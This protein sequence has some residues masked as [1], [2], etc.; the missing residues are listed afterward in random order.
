VPDDNVGVAIRLL[1]GFEVSVAG[2]PVSADAWRLRKAKT[3]V[4]LLALAHGHRIHRDVLADVL[5]PGRTP[6]SASNNLHQA[7]YAAR[8]ALGGAPVAMFRLHEDVVLLADGTLPWLDT[9]A[10][11]E[12]CRR[13][14]ET[15]DPGDFALAAQLYRGDLLPEDRFEDWADAPR[16]AYRD[17]RLGLLADYAGA[18]LER[19]E[20]AQVVDIAG[21]VTAADPFHEG[22]YRILMAAL[23][24]S[25]RRYEALAAFDR[26]REAL[27]TEHAADPEPATRRLYRE[28]LTGTEPTSGMTTDTALSVAQ[29]QLTRATPQTRAPGVLNGHLDQTSFVGRRREMAEIVAAL[30]RTR[31]LTLTGPG[32]AGKTRLAYQVANG[33]LAGF[34][35]GIHLVE[36]ASLTR[37]ELVPQTVASVLDVPLP[38]TGTAEIVLARQVGERHLLLVMDNCEHLLEACARLVGELLRRCPGVVVL[39]TS[40]EPLRVGGEVTWRTP[41]LALP[42][43]RAQL[44]LDDLAQLE[45]VRLFVERARDASP[46]FVLD[47]ETAPAVAE[48]CRRL[49]GMPLALELAAAR[50]SALAP[51]QIADRLGDAMRVLDRGSRS[52]VTRQQTLQATLSWSH[53]LLDAGERVLFRRLAVFAGSMPLE[54]VEQVCGGDD[55]DPLEVVDL[56]SR[57]VDKS[58]VQAEPGGGTVR[59]RLL[60]TIRQFADRKLR[61]SGEAH[62]L[63]RRHRD[64]YVTFAAE[65]DPEQATGVVNDTP[66][67][68][69]DEHDNLRAALSSGL[70]EDPAVALRLAV[71]LWRFWLA[72]GHFSEGSRWLRA[73][74]DAAPQGSSLRV[75]A[76]FAAAAMAVRRGD[77][78]IQV[79]RLGT[80][81][82]SIMRETGDTRAL[83]RTLHLAALL[84][85]V[86]DG[87]SSHSVGL[88]EEART[89]ANSAG[90][91]DVAVSATHLLGVM[92]LSRGAGPEGE[93]YL[94][95]TLEA[96]EH[97]PA[98]L[99]PFFAAVTPGFSWELGPNGQPRMLLTETVLLYRRVG[100][101][102][103]R[104]Y[105]LSNLSY[106]ARLQ[107]D[108]PRARRL[109]EDSVSAFTR[110]GDLHGTS[111]ALCHLA[112]VHRLAG[113]L[114]QAA[115]L[116]DRSLSIRRSLGDRRGVGITLLNQGVLAAAGAD[117]ERGDHLIREALLLFEETEDGPGIW[118]GLLDLGVVLVDA[119]EDDRARR[120]LRQWRDRPHPPWSFRAEAWTLLALATV[121]RRSG[122]PTAAAS[123]WGEA[124]RRFVALGDA[125]GLAYLQKAA[126]SG[127]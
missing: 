116:L 38:E 47:E 10:F 58:L 109:L 80:E 70:A 100:T 106:A 64:W 27:A 62:R 1:G 16:E 83:A 69:D 112:N 73:T 61:D 66:Q 105:T 56:L 118:G 23:T 89:L 35:D 12:A 79:S 21:T 71:S 76:L 3:L 75:Q 120:V 39:V 49:D 9:E 43:P 85:W 63:V 33:L 52:A 88:A 37:P 51:R 34:P 115:D 84:S 55:L 8:R 111:L 59:Y 104:P 41:S 123:Y 40:R 30:R 29:Q 14:R 31:L 6:S 44:R 11:D 57:L 102:Q 13:A 125:A 97:L 67:A 2:Q 15:G 81:A 91:I 72:R 74:M 48:I 42:D 94:T 119:G 45:S 77:P 24:A 113:E 65:N 108:L 68:L 99:P 54:A 127:C 93:E 86:V 92:A 50:T 103:A 7:L 36:L 87:E 26:L 60:E 126:L 53:D 117:V 121:E 124:S 78:A 82:V 122:D 90:A 98:D 96:L 17:R 107:G 22:A 95:E 20:H 19:G 25:G 114:A 32:G 110:V 5:W 28:L 4:K 101:E 18:L 46:G